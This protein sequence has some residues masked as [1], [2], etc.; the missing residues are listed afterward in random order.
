MT[1]AY[2]IALLTIP[3]I[4]LLPIFPAFGLFDHMD[5][6][7]AGWSK[8]DTLSVLPLLTWPTSMT[9]IVF[10]IAI[11]VAMRWIIL[12][13]RLQPGRYSVHSSVYFRKWALALLTDVKLET[14]SSLFATAY[15]R[16]WYRMMG[17]KIG[18]GAEIS[19]NLSGAMIWLKSAPAISLPMKCCWET[20]ISGAAG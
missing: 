19:T 9:L 4:G 10:T 1:C 2:V 5:L 8:A 6:L 18:R 3:P 14:L 13:T 11:T 16:L 12:P 7:I 17:T 20:R 15:M